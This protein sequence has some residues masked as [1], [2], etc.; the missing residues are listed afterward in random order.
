MPTFRLFTSIKPPRS[1]WIKRWEL[2]NMNTPNKKK[3]LLIFSF[4][5]VIMLLVVMAVKIAKNKESTPK[6]RT[7]KVTRGDIITT[8]TA[9]GAI[10]PVTTVQVGIQVSGTI[11]QLFVDFN[12]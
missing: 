7:E 8:A 4:F 3:R 6:F 12:S 11:K 1:I 2:N 10:N 9:T 5:L